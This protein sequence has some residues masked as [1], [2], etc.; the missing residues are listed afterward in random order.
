MLHKL[1]HITYEERGVEFEKV[2]LNQIFIGVFSGKTMLKA[3]P[4][5]AVSLSDGQV[6]NFDFQSYELG[7]KTFETSRM[8]ELVFVARFIENV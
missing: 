4:T 3:T 5:T 2:K 1:C 6:V 8:H 7:G